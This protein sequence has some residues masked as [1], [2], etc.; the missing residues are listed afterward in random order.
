MGPSIPYHPK[1]DIKGHQYFPP[2]FGGHPLTDVLRNGLIS[3]GVLALMS[4]CSTLVLCVFLVWRLIIWRHQWG[5]FLGYNQYVL[6]V[7]NLLMADLQICSSYVISFYWAH[8]NAIFSPSPP[9]FAQGWLLQSGDVRSG[10]FVLAIAIHTYQTAVRGRRTSHK[11][12]T[13]MTICI[14][15]VVSVKQVCNDG[16]LT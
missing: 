1:V 6:L 11:S 3:M 13:I 16:F 15:F 10:F 4:V 12:F 7:L 8:E 5:A 2:P 9:C 14:W